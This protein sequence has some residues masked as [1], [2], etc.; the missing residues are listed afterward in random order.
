MTGPRNPIELNY[1]D[2]L[3]GAAE[4][5]AGAIETPGTAIV[6]SESGQDIVATIRNLLERVNATITNAKEMIAMAKGIN[7]NQQGPLQPGQPYQP[8]PTLGQQLHRIVNVLYGVYGD[9]T[10]VELAQVLTQQYGN[11]KLSAVLKA[12]EHF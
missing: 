7:L 12:L 11:T 6:E 5:T 9:I 3:G 1:E 8:Q 10:V 4:S 2:L